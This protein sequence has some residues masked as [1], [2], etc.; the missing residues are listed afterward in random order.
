MILIEEALG[1]IMDKT[2]RLPSVLTDLAEAYGKVVAEDVYSGE[3]VPP[4]DNSAMDGFAIKAEDTIG[5]SAQRPGVLDILEDLPAGK[6][7]TTEIK[8]GQA[9][10]IMTGAPM[11][12]GADTV[13]MQEE[14]EEQNERILIK[15]PILRKENVRDAGEDIKRGE[16]VI[17]KDKT[18]GPAEIGLLA[19]LGF[20]K[21]RTFATPVVA[22]ISTGD[23]LVEVAE[24]LTPGKIRNSNSYSLHALVL[25]YGG[26]PLRLGIAVD[27]EKV[28]TGKIEEALKADLILTSGGV[29]VGN[30]DFVK[31]VLEKMG[32]ETHFWGVAMKPGKPLTFA[33]LHGQ[34]FF[35]LPGN[36]VAVMVAFEQFVRPALLK[37]MGKPVLPL[38]EV[39]AELQEEI[40]KKPGRTHFIR[41]IVTKEGARYLVSTTGPQG[42]NILKSMVLANGLIVVSRERTNLKKGE[43]VKVQLLN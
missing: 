5:A 21:V 6:S 3:D 1:I 42:S 20:A 43:L 7:T 23:E 32:A 9:I 33:T 15:A 2:R 31:V 29:S 39:E 24:K 22:I 27:Q 4:F 12:R 11:P 16:L 30:F 18:L 13:I 14:V 19:S 34:P 41:G 38:P 8:K 25:K 26:I 17:P 37:M 35:G 28:I 40:T 10:R 36:P